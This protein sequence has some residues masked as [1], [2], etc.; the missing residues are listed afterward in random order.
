MSRFY[1]RNEIMIP[2]VRD[3]MEFCTMTIRE[4]VLTAFRFRHACKRFDQNRR[5]SD[6]D[7]D[8][9]LE[10]ARL[11]PSSFGLEPWRFLVVQNPNIRGKLLREVEITKIPV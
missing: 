7:F 11:S 1:L 6:V 4:D 3:L 8:T 9:I 2:C 5:I 10:C